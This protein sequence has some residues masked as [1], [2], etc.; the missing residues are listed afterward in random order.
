MLKDKNIPIISVLLDEPTKR[1]KKNVTMLQIRDL[2][3]FTSIFSKIFYLFVCSLFHVNMFL[4][5]LF[6]LYTV[7]DYLSSSPL[8]QN[9]LFCF[10]VYFCVNFH[11]NIFFSRNAKIF[12]FSMNYC[13]KTISSSQSLRNKQLEGVLFLIHLTSLPTTKC[14]LHSFHYFDV[15]CPYFCFFGQYPWHINSH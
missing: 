3:L 5:F 9:Q 15:F 1:E 10:L 11:L 8:K 7:T 4:F 12:F 2:I 14:L 13:H 6:S